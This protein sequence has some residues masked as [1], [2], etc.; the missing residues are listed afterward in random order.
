MTA[1]PKKAKPFNLLIV[2]QHGRLAYEAVILAASLRAADPGFPGRLIVA[3]PVRGPKWD[4]DPAPRQAPL[5]AL[6]E[7]FGAE[8]RP[9]ESRAFGQSYPHGNKIEAL[10]VL[11]PGEPFLFLDTDTLITGK[12]SDIRFDFDRPSASMRREGTWPRIEL[13]GPGY[14]AIWRALYNRFGLEIEPTIDRS[15][16]EE[17]W[18][19]YLYFNAGWFFGADPA[20]FGRRFLDWAVALRDDPPAELICQPLDPWL[21]QA[22]LPLVIHSF[23]GGRP[24]PELAG[25]DGDVTCHY[26]TFP[27]LYARESD[28]VVQMLESVTAPNRVKK[29]LK[30]YE[31]ILRTVYQGRGARAR[32]LFDREHLPKREQMIRNR[33]RKA[34]LWMR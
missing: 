28:A 17:Y 34:G 2:A 19:R 33:L 26:R 13:Y 8:L 10:S 5:L 4:I 9:F 25:L 18:A 16:P 20:A 12:L 31:P 3:H 32:A 24:G 11:P 6:L 27:M 30:E 21:D 14:D 23:G 15:Q 22:V 7:G 29:V 1:K